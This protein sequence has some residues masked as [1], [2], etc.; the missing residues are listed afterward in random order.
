MMREYDPREVIYEWF[1]LQ[2]EVPEHLVTATAANQLDDVT[3][4]YQEEESHGTSG[5]DGA[6]GHVLGF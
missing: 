1:C 5:V 2:K 3:V 6:G 4:D